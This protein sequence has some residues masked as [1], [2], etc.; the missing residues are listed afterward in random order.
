MIKRQSVLSRHRLP[1]KYRYSL[2]VLWLTPV[3]IFVLTIV[4]QRGFTAALLDLRFLVP[5]LLM[6]LPAFYVWQ[7]GVDVLAKGIR[8][9][10]HLPRYYAYDELDM[11]HYDARAD[12]HVLTIWDWQSR[13]VLECRG[14]HLSQ[15]PALLESLKTNVRRRPWAS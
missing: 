11:W 5:L 9:R 13:K 3:V 10:L 15:L 8:A 7:E 12:Q 6:G 4:A 14:G 1:G 2:V